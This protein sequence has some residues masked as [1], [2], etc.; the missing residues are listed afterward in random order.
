MEA[1]ISE[2]GMRAGLLPAYVEIM[3]AVDEQD[4]ARAAC[5]EL[6]SIAEGHENGALGAMAAQAR[7][8]VEL[9]RGNPEPLWSRS[10]G[11]ARYGT[12]WKRPTKRHARGSSS[13]LPAGPW[14]TR[15]RHAGARGGRRRLRAARGDA[16]RHPDRLT[17][18]RWP[19]SP[20]VLTGRE[21]EVLRHLAAGKTNK[22][23]AAELVLS[24]RTV[25]RHVSNIFAK[26][27]VSSRTAATAYAYEHRLV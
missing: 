26:L 19:R 12:N 21:L 3:L 9:A 25:D 4:A 8:A 17:R 7:G 22:A 24:E 20:M 11:R 1:E 27:G 23:I 10:A 15:R 13:G 5:R 2:P 16:G 6:E 18:R 14:T